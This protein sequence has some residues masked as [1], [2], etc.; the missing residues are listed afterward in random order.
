MTMLVGIHAEGWDHLILH[1]YLAKLLGVSESDLKPDFIDG[2][3]RGWQFVQ[4]F[5]PKALKLNWLPE[6]PGTLWPIVITVP[7]EMIE[8]WLLA[9]QAVVQPVSGSLHAESE[10][11][12]DQKLRFYGRPE[13]TRQDVETVAL[14]L[15]RAL[16]PNHVA[17][18]RV[19]SRSFAQ[20][21][22]QLD[23]N[24][25]RI[26]GSCDCWQASD[27]GSKR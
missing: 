24:R 26:L 1:A 4:E 3:G 6:K 8:S 14:P 22:D 16:Q 13:P 18:L 12:R 10:H 21:A 17:L 25:E 9:T 20:F 15:I 19:H 2:S 23:H 27:R 11:R 7:V 5:V